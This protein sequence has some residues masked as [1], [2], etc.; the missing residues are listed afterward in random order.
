MANHKTVSTWLVAL[1]RLRPFQA[2]IDYG[3]YYYFEKYRQHY[4]CNYYYLDAGNSEIPDNMNYN[5]HMNLLICQVMC[6][7]PA[8]KKQKR[9]VVNI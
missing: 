9:K 1:G 3:L 2:F 7:T 8:N 6:C 4:A 5:L